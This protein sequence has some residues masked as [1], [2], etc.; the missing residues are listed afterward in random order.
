MTSAVRNRP[1]R[2]GI[3]VPQGEYRWNGRLPRWSDLEAMARLAEEIG[4]DSLWVVDHLLYR[5]P[6]G[7]PEGIWECWSLLSAFAA[8]TKRITLG[9]LVL[10][11]N[12]RNPALI[13]K[14]AETVDEIS[15]GRLILGLGAGNTEQKFRRFGFPWER[16]VSRFAEALAIVHGLLRNGWIDYAG[17][18]YTVRDCLLRPRG[19]RSQGPPILVGGNGPRVLRL[20]AQYADIWNTYYDFTG[21]RASGLG[22]QIEAF[23]AACRDVGRDWSSVTLSASALVAFP[24]HGRIYG[25]VADP[26]R[27]T[28]EE[29][30]E[31]FRAYARAGIQH[32]QLRIEPN[33][34]EG[35][36]QLGRVLEVLDRAE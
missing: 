17:E 2:I 10:C 9:T 12:W 8:V 36:E 32:L 20:A 34:L 33:T 14:M 19:R 16:R 22:P 25:V 28:P 30:A 4:L 6:D 31:E 5:T 11:T 35:L 7:E 26:V 1:L 21:N 18:F 27:G 13:A 29:I 3:L 23:R 15:G 24:G